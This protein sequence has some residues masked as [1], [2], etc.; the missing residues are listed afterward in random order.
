MTAERRFRYLSPSE[1]G[2]PLPKPIALL[3]QS[4]MVRR[5]EAVRAET[6][7]CGECGGPA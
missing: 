1:Y 6:P 4:E 7:R 5:I 2:T 3:T